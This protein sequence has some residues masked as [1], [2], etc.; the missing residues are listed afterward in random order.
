MCIPIE[1]ISED[2]ETAEYQFSADIH[3]PHPQYR[4]GCQVLGQAHGTMSVD[5]SSGEIILVQAMPWDESEKRFS[6]A[7]RKIKE[8][9]EVGEFPDKTIFAC[10]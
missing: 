10:G 9:W 5:K 4:D 3:E 1:K 2:D 7:A 8:H 6:S